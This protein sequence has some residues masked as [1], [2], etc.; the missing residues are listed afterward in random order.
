MGVKELEAILR[1]TD[2]S[3]KE[4]KL[5]MDGKN[6][7]YLYKGLNPF[8][9]RDPKKFKRYTSNPVSVE[10]V[11]ISHAKRLDEGSAYEITPSPVKSG[12]GKVTRIYP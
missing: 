5:F 11:A 10:D 9:E 3:I 1:G 7:I 12:I 2:S 8:F 4:V 6:S